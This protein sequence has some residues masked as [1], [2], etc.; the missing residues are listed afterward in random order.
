MA[1]AGATSRT[2]PTPSPAYIAIAAMVPVTS[3]LGV[4]AE[5]RESGCGPLDVSSVATTSPVNAS[6]A[7]SADAS[8]RWGASGH[9]TEN[10]VELDEPR[11]RGRQA[12][13]VESDS[14]EV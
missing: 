12:D 2:C 6:P 13:V 8:T 4:R 1:A 14:V 5:S 10:A 11:T 3:R 7:A 9:P